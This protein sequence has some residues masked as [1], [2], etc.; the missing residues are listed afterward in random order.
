M[1]CALNSAQRPNIDIGFDT[2]T[3]CLKRFLEF[4]RALKC[5]K[6]LPNFLIVIVTH[7]Y[8]EVNNLLTEFKSHLNFYIILNLTSLFLSF[9]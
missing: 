2:L 4:A 9:G 7:I 1:L 8:E 3:H 5:P 6:H